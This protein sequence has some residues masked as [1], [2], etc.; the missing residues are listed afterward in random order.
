MCSYS[1]VACVLKLVRDSQI[2][3]QAHLHEQWSRKEYLVTFSIV[4]YFFSSLGSIVQI[5]MM[6]PW[7][8]EQME[9]GI[10]YYAICGNGA[11]HIGTF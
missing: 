9:G 5:K 3:S 8:A 11:K 6:L 10:N 2:Q 4:L 7:A 1:L